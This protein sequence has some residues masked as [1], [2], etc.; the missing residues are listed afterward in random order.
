MGY[1]ISLGEVNNLTFKLIA[2]TLK[3]LVQSATILF[4]L[5]E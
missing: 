3:R 5:R 1:R 4:F 2:G